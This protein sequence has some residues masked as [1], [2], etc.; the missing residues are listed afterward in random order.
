MLC[1]SRLVNKAEAAVQFCFVAWPAPGAGSG[2]Q[3]R[4]KFVAEKDL[5]LQ[6]QLVS[7]FS[8]SGNL[9]LFREPA[10]RTAGTGPR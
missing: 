4:R 3:T 6:V 2:T 5:G 10:H 1:T 7:S 8:V 9:P